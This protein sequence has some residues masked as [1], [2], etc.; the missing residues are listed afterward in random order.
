M[1]VL[2]FTGHGGGELNPDREPL[3]EVD[4][5]DEAL[6]FRDSR[7]ELESAV[8]DD[9]LARLLDALPCR[10]KIAILDCCFSGGFVRDLAADGTLVLAACRE[11]G[12]PRAAF[13]HQSSGAF[14]HALVTGLEGEADRDR[15]G[16][17]TQA[18]I[19]DFIGRVVPR[20]CPSCGKRAP[21]WSVR[22]LSDWTRL[23]DPRLRPVFGGSIDVDT[24]A[25]PGRRTRVRRPRHPR[26]GGPLPRCDGALSGEPGA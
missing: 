24:W 3:D 15:D 2:Y 4:S 17:V 18:E 11:D 10:R 1:L 22:C 19:R 9:E 26:R 6:L 16:V 5:R 7:D 23:G 25:K 12:S 13:A 14:T 8:A 21:G 20:Y